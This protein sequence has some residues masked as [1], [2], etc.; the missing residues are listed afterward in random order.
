MKK[1]LQNSF[2]LFTFFFLD[3][4]AFAQEPGIGDGLGDMENEDAPSV[5]INAKLIWLTIVGVVFA[6]YTFKN[7]RKI[8]VC[9]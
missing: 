5:P 8:G 3:I 7:A 6:Y 2:L 1:N 4:V 9:R